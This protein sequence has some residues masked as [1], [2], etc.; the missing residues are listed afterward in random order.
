VRSQL[1]R[2][3]GI[4]ILIPMSLD[5]FTYSP[6]HPQAGGFRLLR[7]KKGIGQH[8]EGDIIH[9][10]LKDQERQYEAVSYTW[11][12]SEKVAV[13]N[14]G[15][16]QLRITPNLNLILRDLRLPEADR[17]LWID[18]ICINQNDNNDRAYQVQQMKYVFGHAIRV[19]FCVGRPTDAT[20]FL[21]DSLQDMPGQT[22]PDV[23][24]LIS[25]WRDKQS[26]L[27]KKHCDP[28]QRQREGL[29]YVLGQPWF[30]R[31]W[32]LQEVANARDG[33]VYCGQKSVSARIFAVAP[34][35]IDIRE[36]QDRQYQRVLDLM[37]GPYKRYSEGSP[38]RDLFWLLR[39]FSSCKATEELDR[40]YALLG[41]CR[42]AIC[43]TS[44]SVD[45]N[46]SAKELIRDTI[47]H[48]CECDSYLL[49]E[50]P[51]NSVRE[52]LDDL[53]SLENT[54]LLHWA[55]DNGHDAVVRLLLVNGAD[56]N[57]EDVN[58]ETLLRKAA[59]NGHEVIVQNL[60]RNGA[61]I[62]LED[63]NGWT[64]LWLAVKNGHR[65]VARRLLSRGANGQVE[66]LG[67]TTTKDK[68][69]IQALLDIG[70]D[71]EGKGSKDRTPLAL[72]ARA[73]DEDIVRLL[74]NSGANVD[75]KNKY[76]T[77][78]LLLAANY[79]FESIVTLLHDNG[80][81]INCQ[82][83]ENRTP[84]WY[85]IAKH[86]ESM[87]L[88]LLDK[89]A[90]VNMKDNEG[91]TLLSG[92]AMAGKLATTQLLLEKGADV[93][94]TDSDGRAPLFWA[95]YGGCEAI[96][97]LLLEKGAEFDTKDN[98]YE[99]TP[100]WC[101]ASQGHKEIVQILLD[102]GASIESTD[103]RG[104]TPLYGAASGGHESV[105]R[106]LLLKGA[107]VQGEPGIETPLHGA[108]A[109]KH[110]SAMRLLLDKGA[111]INARD[112]NGV[113]P[114]WWAAMSGHMTIVR[115]LIDQGA[116]LEA[117][118]TKHLRTPLFMAV[119]HEHEAVVQLLL[120][121]GAQINARDEG[122][123]SPI[124]MARYGEST[125]VRLLQKWGTY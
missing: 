38:R 75:S 113:A 39:T 117:R 40:I 19:L 73:G 63:G 22:L 101:A 100:L 9:A 93:N 20:N 41:M 71:T 121:K 58:G 37:P 33:L 32:I 123:T 115:L 108:A 112:G 43:P 69:M 30:S 35:L 82:T 21:M 95:A 111:D 53:S 15:D 61:S 79:G 12:Q 27:E 44:L 116:D 120:E 49:S 2:V 114:L 106:F 47:S 88:L 1:L 94:L 97:R 109:G 78:A 81:D 26:R 17:M 10:N 28:R 6:L 105:V 54:R 125:M 65:D 23:Q 5:T 90:N 59:K 84:L 16:K 18:A 110:K 8:I 86:N 85:A 62:G 87:A 80:A 91:Q 107:N 70:A 67:A 72:A 89:G 55:A 124:E 118:D 31:V 51:Y 122:G 50:V 60:L 96:V 64:A 104:R 42:D 52:F 83:N 74:I 7:L 57:S 14:I 3:D 48:I 98:K 45:Y 68:A 13:V 76:G 29:E 103:D 77:T 99:N 102:K 56:A 36:P 34:R 4:E 66:L 46:K 119:W 11:G 92:A 24:H 25:I